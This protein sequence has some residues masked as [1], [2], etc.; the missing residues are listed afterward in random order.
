[1]K[2]LMSELKKKY[3][4]L[5]FA[6]LF[7]VSGCSSVHL[8]REA[9]QLASQGEWDEAV[10]RYSELYKNDPL[11]LDYRMK[12]TRARF[13]AAQIH[14]ARGEEQLA[15][16][17]HQAS[18]LEFQAALFLDPSLDKARSSL[19]KTK[20]LMD[21]IYYYAKGLEELTK[22]NER[23]AKAAFKKAVSL[24]PGNE[25]AATELENLKSQ[26]KTVMDG[27]E[28]DLKSTAPID[29]EFKD[30][31][32][33]QLFQVISRLSGINFIFDSELRDDR[34]TITLK[35]ATF[36]QALDLVLAANRLSKKAVNENTLIIYPATAQKAAQYE[37]MMIKVF[38]L[39]NSDA[40]KAV[41]LLRTMVKA[42]D[43][44][45]QEELNAIVIRARPEAI[46][47]AHKVLQATDIADAE[48]MLEV[49][50]MEVNKNKASNLGVD[51]TPDALTVNI[52]TTGGTIKLGDLANL[53]NRDLLLGIPSATLN[54]KKEDLDANLLANPKI[55]VK[56]NGK[57]RIHIGDRI[58]IITTT[59]NQ[60]VSTENIQYQDVGLKLTVEP[61]VR[62]NDE[63]DIKLGLEV[64]S[65]GT[66]TVT[67]SGSVA[68]QIGTR[69][70]ETE[71][72]LRDGETQIFGGLISDEER[73]TTAK[74]PF[75]GEVPILGRVFS[76]LDKSSVKT[77]LLLS[78]T[79]RII[80]KV[81]L[82]EES[83]TGFM[84]GRDDSPMAGP[85]AGGTF[86]PEEQLEQA[87]A[88]PVPGQEVRPPVRMQPR[89]PGF[90]SSIKLGQ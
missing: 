86:I 65:L 28:L 12:Y 20:R 56:N 9:D 88:P 53:S 32:V 17:N 87:V 25:V 31:G 2:T 1:M 16:G 62:Q 18:L 42:R 39:T 48:L 27:F 75:L 15:K 64:S 46:E 84:S 90:P 21:S 50:I 85:Q 23:L 52:P 8:A 29:L 38:Y 45:V 54:I 78:I 59:V 33:K 74:I 55:R 10:L 77:E 82:P 44:S 43:I 80:R 19:E 47:L 72:R 30:A 14:H 7:I 36:K 57:A 3:I 61:I 60:G 81:V 89:P 83:E 79:P 4:L 63:V 40:K 51:L 35:G 69:N 70:T 13:E 76:N 37:E 22:G 5:F 71:L 34:T 73:T 68:Y 6:L 41:N 26:G 58:P 11:S 49:S 24:N 67:S 66:K